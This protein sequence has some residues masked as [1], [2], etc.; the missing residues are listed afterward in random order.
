MLEAI[1]TTNFSKTIK[2][3]NNV[4]KEVCVMKIYCLD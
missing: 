2:V 1:S 3:L 4:T